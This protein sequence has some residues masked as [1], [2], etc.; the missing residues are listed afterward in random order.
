[1]LFASKLD[2]LL[3]ENESE[4]QFLTALTPRMALKDMAFR[5]HDRVGA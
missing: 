4:K 3:E 2:L 5:R 1:M